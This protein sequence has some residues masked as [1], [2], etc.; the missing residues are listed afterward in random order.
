VAIS[1]NGELIPDALVAHEFEQLL[2]TQKL[3]SRDQEQLR[4]MAACAVVDRVLVRQAAE[5][6]PRPVDPREPVSTYLY[7]LTA[8]G[9]YSW[10]TWLHVALPSST[11]S[12]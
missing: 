6:D 8:S 9:I 5:R 4:L 3:G 12:E 10:Y 11:C 1:V 2:K 7:T